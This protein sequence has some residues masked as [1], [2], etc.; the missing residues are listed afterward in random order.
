MALWIIFIGRHPAVEHVVFLVHFQVFGF[1]PA[2]EQAPK[3]EYHHAVANHQDFFLTEVTCES[4][5]KAV[6]AQSDVG[7]TL[8]SRR[9]IPIFAFT[10]APR[11]FLRITFHDSLARKAIE[12]TKLNIANALFQYDS[13]RRT[14]LLRN[15]LRSLQRA[16]VGRRKDHVEDDSV[17]Q[18]SSGL[19]GLLDTQRRKW[20]VYVPQA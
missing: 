3:N 8:A 2:F 5:E 15:V 11:P 10:L 20:R 16:H 18:E 14:E 9:P 13:R 19:D 6:Y 12:N 1:I 4:A 7:P 17:A